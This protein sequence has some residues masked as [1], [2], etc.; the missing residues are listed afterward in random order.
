MSEDMT[1]TL[2]E[3]IDEL[4]KLRAQRNVLIRL[5]EQDD[6]HSIDKNIIRR[7]FDEEVKDDI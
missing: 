3:L 1:K 6:F 5:L 2:V 7:V 4:A